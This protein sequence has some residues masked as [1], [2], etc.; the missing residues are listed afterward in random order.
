MQLMIV[1]EEEGLGK[2]FHFIFSSS[3][4]GGCAFVSGG[5]KHICSCRACRAFCPVELF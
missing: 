1:Y 5:G 4:P 2:F 3:L